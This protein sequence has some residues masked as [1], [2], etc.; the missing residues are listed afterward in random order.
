VQSFMCEDSTLALTLPSLR[1]ALFL[2]LLRCVPQCAKAPGSVVERTRRTTFGSPCNSFF[3]M[4]LPNSRQ[5]HDFYIELWDRDMFIQLP[6]VTKMG[7]LRIRGYPSLQWMSLI[8][9][10][11]ASKK[12]IF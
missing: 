3:A 2:S 12:S 1:R 11:T 4:V 6:Y 10:P 7:H 5:H 9:P 8:L